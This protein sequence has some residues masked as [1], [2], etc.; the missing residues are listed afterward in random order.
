[1]RDMGGVN[2]PS[3]ESSGLTSAREIVPHATSQ[4]EKGVR[5]KREGGRHE[6]R[7]ETLENTE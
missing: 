4:E 3:I 5:G 2:H 1:M 7:Q 6:G